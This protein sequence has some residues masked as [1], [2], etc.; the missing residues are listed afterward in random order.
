MA[1]AGLLST[2]Y[3]KQ[4]SVLEGTGLQEVRAK[5]GRLPHGFYD[6]NKKHNSEPFNQYS[7]S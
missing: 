3:Q 2:P 6:S 5:R 7:I 1:S 4:V